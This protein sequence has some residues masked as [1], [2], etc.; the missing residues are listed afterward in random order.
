MRSVEARVPGLFFISVLLMHLV[1]FLLA[2]HFTRIYMGDSYEYVYEAIN[3]KQHFFF[4]SGSPGLPV[5]EAYM[6]FRPPLY[7]LVLSVI[8]SLTVNNWVVLVLQ[9]L[10]SVFNI[11]YLRKMLAELGYRPKYDWL[12]LLLLLTY[13]AQFIHASTVEPEILL[14][15]FTL[16]YVRYTVLLLQQRKQKYALIM[17][18]ALVLSMLTKPVLYPFAAI[19]FLMLVVLAVRFKILR[20]GWVAAAVFPLL[21]IAGYNSWNASRTGKF[22]FTSN[23]SF[24]AVYYYYFYLRE[25]EGADSARIFLQ[26]ERARIASLHSFK[27]Q[28]DYGNNRGRELLSQNFGGY[29]AYH[30]KNSA[31]FFIDPGKGDIDLFTGRLTYGN[32]YHGGSK[33]FY[34]TVKEKGWWGG[35]VFYLQREPSM[36]VV[37]VVLLFNFVRLS[38]LLFFFFDK[39]QAVL[40]RAFLFFF[41]LYVAIVTGPIATPRYVL[42]V[43]LLLCGLAT[44]GLQ[45]K[46]GKRRTVNI[47]K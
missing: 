15:F 16:V 46:A 9:N 42:P 31:R 13:P 8:Y 11:C 34:A 45:E 21:V 30:L 26:T 36:L 37:I 33:G 40:V 29:M 28:Y 43:S 4:Y 38:G 32:L 3:I 10:L 2:M 41:L 24:N 20:A 1:G 47:G 27:E 5:T 23:Q 14:Q 19:H 22:H 39:K 44:L 17:S 18:L 12:L 35:T 6:T 25:K 7:P